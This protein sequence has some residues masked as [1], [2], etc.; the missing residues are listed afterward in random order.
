MRST[1]LTLLAIV[2]CILVLNRLVYDE[3]PVPGHAE[4]LAETNRFK[5]VVSS[6][7]MVDSN[8]SD[9]Q[10][11]D[12]LFRTKRI[13]VLGEMRHDDGETFRAKARLIRWLHE[14]LDY[15]IVLYEAGQY[16][17]W[18][19]NREM[20]T[21]TM[22]VPEIERPG[23]GLFYFWWRTQ[24]NRPLM[25]Y[26]QQSK[27]SANPITLGG[28][29]IQFSGGA[30][31]DQRGQLLEAYC[32]KNKINLDS[33]PMLQQ[34]LKKLYYLASALYA[35]RQLDSSAK[36]QF[37]SE[38][39]GLEKAVQ[40]LAQDE[41]QQVY[42]KYLADMR[43]NLKRTWQHA[44]G[45]LSSMH[46]RDSLMAQNLCYQLDSL[47]AGKK[48]ILWCAN[49]H[50]FSAPYNKEYRPLGAYLKERYGEQAYMLGFSSYGR[51]ADHGR[52]LDRP[53]KL[54]VEN[55]FHAAGS[56]YFLLDL[57]GL[58]D[59]SRFKQSFV[60]ILN[61]QIAEDRKWSDFFDGI[62]YIDINKKPTYSEQ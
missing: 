41:Q 15:Q 8:F 56:P 24:E 40:A 54:A 20:E 42:A 13:L 39:E 19:M 6:I 53:G 31:R 35:D 17:M 4:L 37:L 26:Y 18:V 62:F 60:S 21:P 47:Y 27:R 45:S 23:L 59:Q 34:Q 25:A 55:V 51:S 58:P 11:L 32:R 48:V 10:G 29:D 38:L 61:Q 1:F 22:L 57:Q 7:A 5:K 33:Y 14:Q 46:I 36:K 12:S 28:F 43:N 50:A 49:I 16:D 2:A 30:L 9:L 3:S 44:A 52:L